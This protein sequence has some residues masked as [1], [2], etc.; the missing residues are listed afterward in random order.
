[1]VIAIAAAALGNLAAAARAA[2]LVQVK[3]RTRIELLPPVRT[4]T[5]TTIEGRVIDEATR[6][7][8]PGI[9]VV[10]S[11]GQAGETE[12]STDEDGSFAFELAPGKDPR[13]VAVSFAGGRRYEPAS[14]KIGIE[15]PPRLPGAPPPPPEAFEVPDEPEPAL[16]G[17]TLIAC[18][19]AFFA[20]GA[21]IVMRARPLATLGARRAREPVAVREAQAGLHTDPPGRSA[22]L[23]RARDLRFGGWIA[24]AVTAAPV[25]GAEISLAAPG[26]EPDRHVF[27][28]HAGRFSETLSAGLWQLAISAA[29]YVRYETTIAMPHHGQL[30]DARIDLLSVREQLFAIY[31]EVAEPLLPDPQLWGVWSPRQIFDHVKQRD[32]APG[33]AELTAFIEEAYFSQR[34]AGEKEVAMARKLALAV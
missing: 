20:V 31:R 10:V 15:P 26:D 7:G 6:A 32:A 25:P 8:I 1:M 28:D 11:T 33:L 4:V 19:V 21:F 14:V 13:E 27:A 29:G 16:V 24:D 22:S 30:A 5:G 18:A 17:S 3:S 34:V 2:P 23:R 12:L 9:D